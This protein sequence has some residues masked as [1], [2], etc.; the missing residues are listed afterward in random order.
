VGGLVSAGEP[1]INWNHPR[2]SPSFRELIR[3]SSR[4]RADARRLPTIRLH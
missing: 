1:R 4:N 3:I 2:M